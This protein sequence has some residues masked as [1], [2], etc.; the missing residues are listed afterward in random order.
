MEGRMI[1][2]E[3]ENFYLVSVYVPNS[4]EGLKRLDY[5]VNE[6][7]KV[8]QKYLKKLRGEKNVIVTGDFNCAHEDIDIYDPNNKAMQPGFTKVERN[9]FRNMLEIGYVDTF[10]Y[11]YPNKMEYTFWANRARSRDGNK[12]WRLDYF[13]V[14]DRNNFV[15]NVEDSQIM[16]NYLGSDHCPIKLII[17]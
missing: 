11:L 2:L 3:Y 17:K 14:S 16:S 13:L 7:D 5:R 9:S 4:G 8:L 1:T 12:G 15:S 6:W 10:R